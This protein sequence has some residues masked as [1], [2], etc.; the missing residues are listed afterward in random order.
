MLGKLARPKAGYCGQGLC[1]RC[2]RLGA[3]SGKAA[4]R[5]SGCA[6]ARPWLQ[7]LRFCLCKGI[8]AATRRDAGFLSA[9][10][11]G[12]RVAAAA[13]RVASLCLRCA[14]EAVLRPCGC[15]CG[16]GCRDLWLLLLLPPEISVGPRT[17]PGSPWAR[18]HCRGPQ[19]RRCGCELASVEHGIQDGEDFQGVGILQQLPPRALREAPQRRA[20]PPGAAEHRAPGRRGAE[21]AG[22]LP[23][24]GGQLGLPAAQLQ[25]EEPPVLDLAD[26][27]DGRLQQAAARGAGD[28]PVE[29]LKQLPRLHVCLD[30]RDARKAL[31]QGP[32]GL[33]RQPP[34]RH[35]A[36]R[37]SAAAWP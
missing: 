23:D 27:E 15:S 33:W 28:V 6:A 2:G 7:Q 20:E 4:A 18:R 34:S 26:G 35:A 24:V 31:Q 22:A 29:E 21:E 8:V 30:L 17:A 5:A 10:G 32:G 1:R 25:E 37:P 12:E 19:R 9:A 36:A 3:K 13:P 14:C 11:Q 16:G